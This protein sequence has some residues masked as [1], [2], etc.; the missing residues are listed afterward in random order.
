VL[1][2]QPDQNWLRQDFD[3]QFHVSPFH[4][5]DMKYHWHSNTP[6]QKLILHLGNSKD[7][8]S[9]FDASL[10]LSRTPMTA[11]GLVAILARYPFMTLKICAA[12][13]WQALRLWVKGVPLYS[14][15]PPADPASSNPASSNPTIRTASSNHE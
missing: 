5:M 13:Y 14:H 7:G 3:K 12:I 11:T 6:G 8:V 4:P 1:T 2:A 15:P 9:Q 10:S